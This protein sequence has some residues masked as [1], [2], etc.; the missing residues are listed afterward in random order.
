ME[1]DKTHLP[2]L[3]TWTPLSPRSGVINAPNINSGE[4]KETRNE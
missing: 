2:N 3:M 1:N 4:K